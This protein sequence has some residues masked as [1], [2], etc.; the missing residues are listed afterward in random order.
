MNF[1]INHTILNY[2]M[3]EHHHSDDK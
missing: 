1:L 2:E 3:L